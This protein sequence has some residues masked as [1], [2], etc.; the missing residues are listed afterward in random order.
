ML[1]ADDA[2]MLIDP[3]SRLQTTPRPRPRGGNGGAKS[4]PIAGP[5]QKPTSFPAH[6]E[7]DA[8]CGQK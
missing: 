5:D 1:S 3:R 2:G 6:I 4:V 8:C 7:S